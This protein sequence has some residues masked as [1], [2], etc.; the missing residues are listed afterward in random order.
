[1]AQNPIQVASEAGAVASASSLHIPGAQTPT[2]NDPPLQD[3]PTRARALQVVK[4]KS[5]GRGELHN[6]LMVGE[7]SAE[8]SL[9][10][11]QANLRGTK[12]CRFF[13]GLGFQRQ[14]V[15]VATL[16]SVSPNTQAK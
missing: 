4:G 16:S 6:L 11:A 13:K 14:V 8:E 7:P 3:R 5:S 10:A 9:R 12:T 1:M 2:V 15:S